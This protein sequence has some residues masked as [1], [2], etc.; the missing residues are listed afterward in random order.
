M[1]RT[2]NFFL[3]IALC[4]ARK[5]C[6]SVGKRTTHCILISKHVIKIKFLFSHLLTTMLSVS[7]EKHPTL[8]IFAD[9]KTAS[10]V[11]RSLT[12]VLA[13]AI[14][15]LVPRLKRSFPSNAHQERLRTRLILY[16]QRTNNS[17]DFFFFVLY[18]VLSQFP[19]HLEVNNT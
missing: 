18:C 14:V 7:Q 9:Q 3:V 1:V 11:F 15:C 13:A 5:T 17:V 16:Q 8:F 12:V 6:Q 19:E 4:K 10:L 2:R